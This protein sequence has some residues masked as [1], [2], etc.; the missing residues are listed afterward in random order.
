MI[1][2][3]EELWYLA[4]TLVSSGCQVVDRFPQMILIGFAEAVITVQSFTECFE[5]CLNS[6]QLYAMNCT[7]VMFFYE[8]NV[9]NCI[10]NSENRRTQKK[11]FVEE[12][13]DIVDYFEM[14]CSLTN[15]NK[16]VK[17]EQPLKS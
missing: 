2:T 7:S 4:D 3:T 6:R 12:N 16:E 10:L 8:E 17:Y 13:K 14:N 5:N 1:F 11:L 9:H 15:Q